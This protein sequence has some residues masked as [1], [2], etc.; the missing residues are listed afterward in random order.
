MH[1]SRITCQVV[2]IVLNQRLG[3]RKILSESGFSGFSD[4]QDNFIHPFS[5]AFRVE[6][7]SDDFAKSIQN[8]FRPTW[9]NLLSCLLIEISRQAR[10]DENPDILTFC[11]SVKS[12]KSSVLLS[13]VFLSD[14]LSS[15][16]GKLQTSY[17]PNEIASFKAKGRNLAMTMGWQ[18]SNFP[19]Y[20][21]GFGW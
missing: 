9:R 13:E 6:V 20:K 12:E 8:S 15:K 5:A 7:K 21:R 4:F 14:I 16:F 10:N 2:H 17:L 18:D 19:N 11:E 1:Q 3:A